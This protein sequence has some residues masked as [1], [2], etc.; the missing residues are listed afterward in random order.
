M[1][2]TGPAIGLTLLL[3]LPAQASVLSY[4]AA[5]G[6]LPEAQ[7]WTFNQD[8]T[9][10]PAPS[11]SGG[12]LHQGVTDFSG[13]QY[14]SSSALGFD[15][16]QAPVTLN[17]RLRIDFASY[18][19]F[20][21]GGYN[22]ILVDDAGRDAALHITSSGVFLGNDELTSV[23]GIIGFNT[24][25]AFHDYH[26][27]AGPGG[28]SLSIDGNAIVSLGL[29][30]AT[31]GGAAVYFGDATLLGYNQS[32]L[33][34]IN[35]TTQDMPEPGTLALFGLGLACLTRLRAHRAA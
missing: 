20:P 11:V 18:H 6:S 12:V 4:D 5:V 7:G 9:P 17:A 32:Q 31:S 29:G 25:D 16:T 10:P 22:L 27:V 33:Q 30:P 15:F 21:R 8:G 19:P 3:A 26:L 23:S 34:F 35:V 24:T 14:W 28:I 13:H 2:I 1:H